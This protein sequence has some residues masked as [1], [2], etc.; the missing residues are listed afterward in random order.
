LKLAFFGYAWGEGGH[1]DGYMAEAVNAYL[2]LGFDVDVYLAN[3]FAAEPTVGFKGGGLLERLVRHLREQDYVAAVSMNNA[4]VLAPVVEALEGR[5]TSVI[6]DG[7]NHLFRYDDDRFAAF[8]L[9]AHFAPIGTQFERDILAG[10]PEAA[11]RVT[12]LTPATAGMH[13][14]RAETPLIYSI[15][16]IASLTT[17]ARAEV[18]MNGLMSDPHAHEVVRACLLAIEETGDLGQALAAHSAVI[19]PVIEQLGLEF[20]AFEMILQD[21]CTS[22]DRVEVVRRLGPHGLALFGN[23]AWAKGMVLNAEV[24]R[25]YRPGP[26]VRTHKDLLNV[27]NSSKLSVNLP[28]SFISESFQYRLLDVMS[29]NALLVTRRTPEPDLYRVFGPDCPVVMFDSPEDLERVC[30]HY[31][32]NED[33]RAARVAACNSLVTEDFSFRSR[34]L[35]YLRLAGVDFT[36]PL[37]PPPRGRSQL[38]ID[39]TLA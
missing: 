22:R 1:L 14:P 24:Y 18:M 39:E 7:F 15:S 16:W 11:G 33:E 13:F 30:A 32:T 29:S 21:V 28:Q 27:Y 17:D 2:G 35:D 8:R 25:A 6:V 10:A 23:P 9:P 5:V 36:P 37:S 34:A 19:M 4:L 38:V 3:Y 12:F 20:Q 26:A 31:L